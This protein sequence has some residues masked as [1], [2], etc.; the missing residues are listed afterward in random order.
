MQIISYVTYDEAGNLTGF[1]NQELQ[2][3]HVEN[4]IQVEDP[5][6]MFWS[7]WVNYRANE[8]R[9]GIELIPP[10]EEPPVE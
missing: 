1:Y 9:D 10:P 3:E 4:Y 7:V 5:D 6:G 8:A 2:P